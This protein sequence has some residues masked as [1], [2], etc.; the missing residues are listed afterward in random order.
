[1]EHLFTY[2]TLKDEQVQQYIFG[3]ILI[4]KSDFLKGFQWHK[5]AVYGRYPL[6][7]Q[8]NDPQHKVAGMVY[9][10]SNSDLALADVYETSAYQRQMVTLESGLEAWLYVKNSD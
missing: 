10:V 4:G 8:T 6:V 3:R 7:V 9:E 2:G 1:M 5:N